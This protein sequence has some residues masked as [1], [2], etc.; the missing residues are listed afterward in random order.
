MY[1]ITTESG[2]VYLVTDHLEWSCEQ[3]RG[4]DTDG[5]ATGKFL[6]LPVVGESMRLVWVHPQRGPQFRVTS[7]VVSIEQVIPV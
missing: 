4:H 6:T 7:P 1:R 2:N 5:A 3:A